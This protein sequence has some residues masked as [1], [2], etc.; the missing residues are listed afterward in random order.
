M[1]RSYSWRGCCEFGD[2][3]TYFGRYYYKVYYVEM[4]LLDEVR[5]GNPIQIGSSALTWICSAPVGIVSITMFLLAW[6]KADQMNHA[7]KK[8]LKQLDVIGS[9]LLIG[10][11]VLVVFAF[12]ES[13]VHTNFWGTALFIVPLATGCLCWILLIGW[14]VVVPTFMQNSVTPLFPRS[15]FKRRVY[16]AGALTTLFTGFPY[17]VVIYNIPLYLQVVNGK[18]PLTAGL[19]LL[20]L[21]VSSAIGST[22]GGA[23]SSKKDLSFYSLTV[24]SCLMTLGI[25]LMSTISSGSRVDPK[26]Y[27]FEVF[28]G[29]G[30]GLSV[31]TSSI[32]AAIQCELTDHGKK[33]NS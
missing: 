33:C 25:G 17:F 18:S 24:A 26:L 3:G 19:G 27:G 15:L 9:F 7:E 5:T 11:S 28:V 1:G 12:Q 2:H 20:P 30:F 4:D 22:L 13:G 32:L 14:E 10:A 29:V 6:P 31:S 21:L 8:P 23:I 16:V